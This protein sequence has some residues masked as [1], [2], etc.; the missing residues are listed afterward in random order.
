MAQS[1]STYRIDTD[2]DVSLLSLKQSTNL[3]WILKPV[4]I[5]TTTVNCQMPQLVHLVG[6]AVPKMKR[7]DL[8]TGWKARLGE[9]ISE[10]SRGPATRYKSKS[11]QAPR[12]KN[13]ALLKQ[14]NK[15]RSSGPS[16]CNLKLLSGCEC[17][18]SVRK[19][20]AK[21]SLFA[22]LEPSQPV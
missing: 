1:R 8:A 19:L 17:C 5:C 11:L 21:S 16:Q 2:H 6:R 4:Y 7:A 14:R 12:F 20:N 9:A 13:V 10:T 15:N 3:K 22:N 18:T